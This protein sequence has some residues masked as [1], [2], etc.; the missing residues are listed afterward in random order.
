M[1][2]KRLLTTALGAFGLGALATGPVF[3]DDDQI[4]APRLYGDISSCAGG[5]L[6]A[7][8]TAMGMNSLLGMG[9]LLDQAFDSAAA[10]GIQMDYTQDAAL[11]LTDA[12]VTSLGSG[13]NE[14]DDLLEL[15]SVSDCN[16]PV[17]NNV[18]QAGTLYND[19]VSAKKAFEALEEPD[20]EDTAAFNTARMNKEDFGGDVY[21]TVYDQQAK[22]S[23]TNKAISDYNKLAGSMGSLA[24][25]KHNQTPS[26]GMGGYDDIVINV[27]SDGSTARADTVRIAD[28]DLAPTGADGSTP[29]TGND[30]TNNINAQAA[31]VYGSGNT[32]GFRA[33][34]GNNDPTATAVDVGTTSGAFNEAGALQFDVGNQTAGVNT[35][36]VARASTAF[37]TLGEIA[38]ELGR[39]QTAVNNADEA[40]TDAQ[41]AGNLDTRAEQETLRRAT[42]GRDHVQGELDRLTRVVRSQNLGIDTGNRVTILGSDDTTTDD[43]VTYEKERDL[44]DAYL[45]AR[46]NVVSAANKVRTAVRSLDNAN[47]ALQAKLQDPDS[48]LNQLVTLREYQEMEAMNALEEAGGEDALQS[49]KDAVADAGKAVTAAK[50]QLAAHQNL[51]SDPASSASRLLNALLEPGEID[52]ETNPADDDG[53]ALVNAIAEVDGKIADVAQ[54]IQDVED[55]AGP[56]A[57]N[58]TAIAEN[59][60]DITALDGRV[61]AN[62]AE[63]G[64]DENGMS[65]IDHNEARSMA[66]ATMIG[67][68][69]TMITTNA[70]NIATNAT[71]IMTN[72]SEIMR[73]EG[74]VDTNWDAIAANQMAI[75][76]N[77]SSI[78]SNADAIAANMNSIGSNASAI[79]DNRN[80]IGELSDDLDV[81]RAGVAASMALAG[82]PAINGRGV[83]IG[84]GSFDGESAFAVGFQIQGEMASFK[85]GVTSASGA[86]GASAGVGFQF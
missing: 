65:R 63:I 56:V 10:A 47:R 2:L 16:N 36:V 33:I 84:V 4:P 11:L 75:S 55:L 51:N 71:N 5:M 60:N 41:E 31:P 12:L 46:G 26:G 76:D 23:A 22:F 20:A 28:L 3:A 79:G 44:V 64:M 86:T 54:N 49:F 29:L 48:Y 61:A 57:A 43:D 81:V 21:N 13:T 1:V 50:A 19:Y 9:G 37:D 80:M 67:E 14:T 77:A 52:G 45:S 32:A 30:K 7:A 15:L 82:M 18:N 40:L 27:S 38:A 66:N 70:E 53:L 8:S 25:L 62:E 58:T 24:T 17:A 59:A 74:R 68:N 78:S 34:R 83:S 42:L 85:V 6:P 73:V 39:W 69:R 35:D 72:A